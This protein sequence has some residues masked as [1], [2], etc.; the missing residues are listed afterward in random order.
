MRFSA[1]LNFSIEEKT[2][3]AIRA[4]A[5]ELTKISAERIWVELTKLLV[6]DHPE[7]I[8]LA[9]DLGVTE[10]ILPEFD[11]LMKTP[12]NTP[13]HGDTVGEHTLNSLRALAEVTPAE[14]ATKS[15][16][17]VPIDAGENADKDAAKEEAKEA[18]YERRLIRWSLLLH[19]MGKPATRT[20]DRNF[21][22]HFTG[23]AQESSR[24]AEEILRRLKADNRIIHD[25]KLL[26]E[27]HDWHA[28]PSKRAV[29]RAVN[30][31]GEDLFPIFLQLQWADTVSHGE[32]NKEQKLKR[33]SDA[34][35][36]FER[37][38][39]QGDC[40]TLSGLAISGRDLLE[41]GIPA[42]P[43]VGELL[44]LALEEVLEDPLK[45]ERSY[46]LDFVSKQDL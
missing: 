42:G 11:L 36:A 4:H 24:I 37:I 1:Q 45:N 9:Y 32:W 28:E 22:D 26:V 39:A 46:L 35:F 23:H 27:N 6:S 8:R 12:Q 16:K 38:L 17:P 21:I 14:K 34:A 5:P 25:V 19:D 43:R 41:L 33:I 44:N 40:V 3:E 29:R 15:S 30:R 18:A 31:T 2:R 13:H 10:V 7:Y 20:T